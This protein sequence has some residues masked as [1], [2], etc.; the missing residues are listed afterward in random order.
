MLLML[1]AAARRQFG[2]RSDRVLVALQRYH[3]IAELQAHCVQVVRSN[4]SAVMLSSGW[5]LIK[6]DASVRCHKHT[7]VCACMHGYV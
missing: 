7:P 4:L 3:N 1:R 2:L 6:D 5:S